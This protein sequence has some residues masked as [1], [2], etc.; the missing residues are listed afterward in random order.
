MNAN[1][2]FQITHIKSYPEVPTE[3]KSLPIRV[4]QLLHYHSNWWSIMIVSSGKKERHKEFSYLST[5]IHPL[6]FSQFK[7]WILWI[8]N[9]FSSILKIIL[10]HST[11]IQN[12][13][14]FNCVFRFYRF[15]GYF[16]F[17]LC[18]CMYV[19]YIHRDLSSI[20]SINQQWILIILYS[21]DLLYAT[22][23]WSLVTDIR[24]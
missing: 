4:V 20:E 8:E 7:N 9:K 13:C 16:F 21:T 3:K 14:T 2:T 15:F 18:V 10:K 12:G 6:P 24:W 19:Q 17:M 1:I 11:L 5:M 23:K 22:R